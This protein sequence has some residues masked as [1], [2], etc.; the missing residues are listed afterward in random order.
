[1]KKRKGEVVDQ[2]GNILKKAK[3]SDFA[4]AEENNNNKHSQLVRTVKVLLQKEQTRLSG[5][6]KLRDALK[7]SQNKER[8][9]C[10]VQEGGEF[11]EV[12]KILEGGR[13]SLSQLEIQACLEILESVLLFTAGDKQLSTRTGMA[14]VQQVLQ[15]HIKLLYTCLHPGNPPDVIM[16]TLRLLTAMVTQGM[17]AAR[18]VQRSFDFTLK[19]IGAL[20]NKR[21]PKV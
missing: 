11:H 19:A 1:M 9:T 2:E 8:L 17:T 16:T 10:I 21:D 15:N 6:S 4:E 7:E 20:P 18:E 14:I 12:F 13:H 5:L 3:V